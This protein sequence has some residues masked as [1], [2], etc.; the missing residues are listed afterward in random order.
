MKYA[1]NKFEKNKCL[2][3]YSLVYPIIIIIKVYQFN[4]IY[5]WLIFF[6]LPLHVRFEIIKEIA[7]LFGR[8]GC[9]QPLLISQHIIAKRSIRVCRLQS[10]SWSSGERV[11][12]SS[13][14]HGPTRS[15]RLIFCGGSSGSG[16]VQSCGQW[17]VIFNNQSINGTMM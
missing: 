3:V 15:R 4:S 14:F 6:S 11:Y 2:Y 13:Y 1:L 10:S 17:V 12:S 16:V 9:H 7:H 5:V 8:I